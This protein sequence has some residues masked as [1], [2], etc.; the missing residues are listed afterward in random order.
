[1]RSNEEYQE[2][3]QL[4]SASPVTE[5]CLKFHGSKDYGVLGMY[6][7]LSEADRIR[8]SYDLL[9]MVKVESMK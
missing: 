7:V 8:L 4:E 9:N 1:M 2:L 5:E 6:E 3:V